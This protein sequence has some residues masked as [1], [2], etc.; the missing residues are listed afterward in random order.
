MRRILVGR[1]AAS[2]PDLALDL[3]GKISE[4]SIDGDN[5]PVVIEQQLSEYRTTNFY[6][7]N[8][9]EVRFAVLNRKI[10]GYVRRLVLEA[11]ETALLP[12]T[13]GYQTLADDLEV[14]HLMP[15]RWSDNDW[16]PMTAN[17]SN[18][19]LFE[20]LG[21]TGDP[22]AIRNDLIDTLGNLTLITSGLNKRLSNRSWQH[23]RELVEKSDNLF[24]NKRLLNDA[25]DVWDEV[26]ILRRGMWIADKVCEI[27]PRPEG[28]ADH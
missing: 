14:E 21:L 8:D 20:L 5:L 10:P 24:I 27:W 9:S 12:S 16:P 7:P 23:K 15:Q 6:W 11:I 2:Y 26:R 22:L 13:A 25:S 19:A 1:Q 17:D 28:V 3:I 18:K 4:D